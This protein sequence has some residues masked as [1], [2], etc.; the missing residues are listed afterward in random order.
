M[1][2][3]GYASWPLLVLAP[4]IG[5]FLGVLIRRVPEGRPIV[6]ARS[7]CE[8]CGAVLTARDLVPLISWLLLRGRCRRC[9][10]P[11]GW[12]YPGIEL[13]AFA[14]AAVAVAV[15]GVP[16]AWVDCL[17]GW[18]LL[19]LAWID[20][21]YWLLPD[22]LTLPLLLTGLIVAAALN[23]EDLVDRAAAAILGYIALRLVSVLYRRLRH[24]EGLG[25]GDAKLLGAAGAWLGVAAL[26]Q[27]VVLSAL[28][29][30]SAAGAL[31]LAGVRLRAYSALPFGPF[32]AAAIWTL[33]LFRAVQ[34]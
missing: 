8:W 32:L 19:A 28:A 15:D 23:P 21:R 26:P 14:V 34:F 12:F 31:T 25:E 4:F 3:P 2:S 9:G 11:I 13:A 20:L 5:S 1:S 10:V 17:L 6:A 7:A 29:A 16:Q 33:W 24:R 18:P 22:V 27:V 30:L